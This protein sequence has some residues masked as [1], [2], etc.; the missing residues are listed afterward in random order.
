[1]PFGVT[2]ALVIFMDYMNL[3]LRLWLDKF[4]VVFIDDIL[5]YLRDHEKHVEHLRIVLETLRKHQ[6]FGKLSK[7]EFWLEEIQFLGHVISAK[8]IFVDPTKVEAVLKW[9][10]PKTML[11]IRSF[12]GLAGY[13]RRFF[14]GFSKIVGPLTQLPRKEQ[15]FLWTDK[16]ETSFE[17]MKKRLT[18]APVLAITDT[19]KT[20]EVFCDASYHGLGCVLM[21][22]KR[23]IAY[24][25]R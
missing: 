23:P 3:I 4:V 24:A 21:Q 10:R 12:M 15:P 2:N 14:E 6:L 18:S 5:I 9:E 17:E 20:F 11:E 22:E 16:C 7:C 25:S 8:G 13:C 1:M 19:S